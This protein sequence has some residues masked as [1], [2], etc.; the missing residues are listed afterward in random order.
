M[1]VLVVTKKASLL[2]YWREDVFTDE[3][4]K[5]I[6][7]YDAVEKGKKAKL[8]LSGAGLRITQ[9]RFLQSD[10]SEFYP[11]Q[12]VKTVAR[13]PGAPR[14]VMFILADPR[15]K[16]QIIAVRCASEVD[17]ADLI[18][19]MAQVK[20]DQ[21]ISNVEF[22]KRDNGNWTLRERSAHNANR[23]MADQLFSEQNNN[24]VTATKTTVISTVGAPNGGVPNHTPV[25]DARGRGSYVKRQD[26]NLARKSFRDS[27]E[28]NK[29]YIIE[30]EVTTEK[31]QPQNVDALKGKIDSLT[32][33]LREIKT[34]ISQTAR[35]DAPDGKKMQAEPVRSYSYTV[36]ATRTQE[37]LP[38]RPQMN[39]VVYQ[40]QPVI[41]RAPTK[42]NEGRLLGPSATYFTDPW[43]AHRRVS[44]S[45]T[46]PKKGKNRKDS[47]QGSNKVT[48]DNESVVS[49]SSRKSK[50]LRLY[51]SI[52]NIP[53]TIERSIEDTYV[54]PVIMQRHG[55]MTVYDGG[56]PRPVSYHMVGANE[57]KV[58]D[59]RGK[60]Y[61]D[62][63]L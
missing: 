56:R 16:Y 20:K 23:L 60:S 31:S 26:S 25:L 28:I 58:F 17:A 15:R 29:D 3:L 18:N 57:L 61:D 54:R 52:G 53:S 38:S 14:C 13:N 33:E 2:G 9:P 11:I 5:K 35:A 4:L 59:A 30:T 6:A 50:T 12:N 51:S 43:A 7:A 46:M 49:N 36:P 62:V 19:F 44:H 37:I 22:R 47:F 45:F 63:A 34:F 40:Q 42:T 24:N 21:Q 55:S 32:Q 1:A 48:F 27:G 41:Y 39:R 8:K 10:K